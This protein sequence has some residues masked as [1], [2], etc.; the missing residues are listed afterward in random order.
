MTTSLELAEVDGLSASADMH[1]L[2]ESLGRLQ[3]MLEDQGWQKLTS[4]ATE[5]FSREGLKRAAEVCRVMAVGN[6]LIKRGLAVRAGYVMGQGVGITARASGDKATQDV[7]QVVQ[8]FLDDPGNRAA[9]TGHQAHIRH[10]NALGTDGNVLI[11]LFTSPLT[12]RVKARLL[13]FDEVEEKITNPEDRTETWF[14]K[15]TFT[16]GK[17]PVTGEEAETVTVFYP[18]IRH[19]PFTKQRFIDNHPVRWDAPVYHVQDN[20]L[21][22]WLWGIGDAYAALPWARAYKG[23]LED[24]AQLMQSLSRIVWQVSSGKKSPSLQARSTVQNMQHALSPAGTAGGA[25]S[26]SGDV[27]VEA[28]PK[29]GATIDAESGRPLGAMTAAALGVPVTTLMADPGQTGARAVAET[30][31]QPTR[32]EFQGRRE[33]WT[34]C[35]RAVL[36]YVIDQAIIAPQGPLKGGIIRDGDE[37]YTTLN[38]S[39]EKTLDIVWPDLEEI[40]PKILID[41][42]VAADSTGKLPPLEVARLLLRALKVR[43]VDEIL[44]QLKDDDGNF[45]D[46]MTAVNDA[47]ARR[48]QRGETP[49][50]AIP[51]D[52]DAQ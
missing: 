15:R 24:W 4:Q 28:I 14:Y 44:D 40:D 32:L 13:P 9:F 48:N 21:E 49:Y 38:G 16:K 36:G 46:P 45:V 33:L 7:N 42:I 10:E 43:D 19:R 17:N 47:A 25:V 51:D 11:A 6:P 8:E 3:L 22:G 2:M 26:T 27:S 50:P 41:S 37:L 52:Q 12:G 5:E 30:L 39:S 34:E 23:F 29:S 1:E 18:D 31:N 35:Y 20:G